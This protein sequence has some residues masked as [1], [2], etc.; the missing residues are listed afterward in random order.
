MWTTDLLE[1]NSSG[2]SSPRPWTRREVVWLLAATALVLLS[3]LPFL[4]PGYGLMSD[5]WGSINI[6][7][8]IHDTGHYVISR[9]PGHPLF[10]I[11]CALLAPGGAWALNGAA[12]L[13]GALAFFCFALILRRLGTKFYLWTALALAFAP[14]FYL[15][16]TQANNFAWG[17]GFLL[18]SFYFVLDRRPLLAG[19]CLGLATGSRATSLALSLPLAMMM[20][21]RAKSGGKIKAVALMAL[22]STATVALCYYPVVHRVGAGFFQHYK[23]DYPSWLKFVQTASELCWG[24]IGTVALLAV[25]LLLLFRRR[26]FAGPSVLPRVAGLDLAAWL[27]ALLIGVGLFLFVPFQGEY[28]LPVLPFVLLLSARWSDRRVHLAFCGVLLISSFLSFPLPYHGAVLGPQA[29]PLQ[30]LQAE[31]VAKAIRGGFSGPI[32]VYHRRRAERILETDAIAAAIRNCKQD[33][34]FVVS[35]HQSPVMVRLT[36]GWPSRVNM[37]ELPSAADL[38]DR[39]KTDHSIIYLSLFHDK[40]EP[41]IRARFADGWPYRT[42]LVESL[43]A[44]D[45]ARCAKQGLQIYYLPGAVIDKGVAG[46]ILDLGDLDA[47]KSAPLP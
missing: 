21:S 17:L 29:D 32:L 34:L 31:N 24:R 16:S 5:C 14:A 19:L 40:G 15:A 35:F 3:R 10:E 27:L 13:M 41:I 23:I 11:G 9:F 25:G 1:S 36:E 44:P 39:E 30:R 2:A 7:R 47:P 12:A 6:G 8:V 33:A 46:R 28:L 45:V 43:T 26:F 4:S 22:V 37:T 38:D 42:I 18:A 20:F